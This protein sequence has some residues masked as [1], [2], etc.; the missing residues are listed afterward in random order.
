M[1]ID[2]QLL[3]TAEAWI[4]TGTYEQERDFLADHPQLLDPAADD[5]LSEALLPVSQEAADRYWQLRLAAQADGAQAAYQPLLRTLLARTFASGA[6]DEQRALLAS[7]RDDLLSPTATNTVASLASENDMAAG[8]AMALLQLAAAGDDDAVFDALPD[9]AR[10][11]ELLREFAD[12]PGPAPLAAAATVALTI[13]STAEQAAASVFY[14]AIAAAIAGNTGR[15]ATLLAQ[16]R[17]GNPGQATVWIG[18]LAGIG[19]QH[20][21]VLP[22]IAALTQ[23]LTEP[24]AGDGSPDAAEASR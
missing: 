1:A 14:L 11:L 23:P 6:P 20:Q 17:Q 7:Q 22:L 10:L 24:G 13:A 16:A 15:A 19:Q 21:A 2:P 4:A 3:Q 18:W 8:R 12:R 9:P 5:A